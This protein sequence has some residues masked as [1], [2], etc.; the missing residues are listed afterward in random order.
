MLKWTRRKPQ[1]GAGAV[2]PTCLPG[3]EPGA[4]L[5]RAVG[6]SFYQPALEAACGRRNGEEVFFECE[7]ALV[8]EPENQHDRNAV[9]VEVEG[10]LTAHLARADA[11]QYQPL[12]LE[13]RAAGYAALCRALI[14]GRDANDPDSETANLGVC[15]DVA[16]AEELSAWLRAGGSALPGEVA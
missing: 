8:P 15:L 13:L 5:L 11:A 3:R 14:V 16:S 1:A 4:P 10:Q 12:L 7:A 6:E 2:L 9:R